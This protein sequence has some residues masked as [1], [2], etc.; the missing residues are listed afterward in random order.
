ME[1][2]G[3]SN[4]DLAGGDIGKGEEEGIGGEGREDGEAGRKRVQ[5]LVDIAYFGRR[6]RFA[7][8]FVKQIRRQHR[9]R[10]AFVQLDGVGESRGG[11][12]RSRGGHRIRT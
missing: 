2:T 3:G 12:G 5:L 7:R 6:V 11:G 10:D 4:D 1:L 9:N 8:Q